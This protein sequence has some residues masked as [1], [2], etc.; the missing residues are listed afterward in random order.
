LT[1]NPVS[2]GTTE[3]EAYG[4]EGVA[5]RRFKILFLSPEPADPLKFTSLQILQDLDSLFIKTVLMSLE[6]KKK[7]WRADERRLKTALRREERGEL[8]EQEKAYLTD[9]AE[10]RGQPVQRR[11]PACAPR[12]DARPVVSTSRPAT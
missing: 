9:M 4:L 12:P 2:F 3:R 11:V 10:K 6:P 7:D 8:A 1:V 5:G